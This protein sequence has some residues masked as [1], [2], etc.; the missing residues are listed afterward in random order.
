[1]NS[2]PRWRIAA[3]I[4]V[5]LM[6]LLFAAVLVPVYIHNLQFQSYVA[7][8]T[9]NASVQAMDDDALRAQVLA[10]A[11]SLHLSVMA[12][13]VHISH[14]AGGTHVA[15]RYFVTVSLPGYT[16]NLH[17]GPGGPDR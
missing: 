12:H 3:G 9:Q 10:K 13:D 5:L 14:T 11:R 7:S 4:A 2:I 17:F 8:L 16:A 15:V 1:V 6:M